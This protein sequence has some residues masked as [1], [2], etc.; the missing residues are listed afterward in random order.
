MV[1][2]VNQVNYLVQ[3]APYYQ[4]SES[5]IGCCLFTPFMLL[6]VAKEAVLGSGFIVTVDALFTPPAKRVLELPLVEVRQLE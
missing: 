6:V 3:I 5:E 2:E 1:M 4:S